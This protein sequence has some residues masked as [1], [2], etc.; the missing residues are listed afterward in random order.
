MDFLRKFWLNRFDISLK[1]E[2]EWW[3]TFH[4]LVNHG[5]LDRN[6]RED[7]DPLRSSQKSTGDTDNCEQERIDGLYQENRGDV[8]NVID[9]A[10]TFKRISGTSLKSE[11]KRTRLA[12]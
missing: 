6:E 5:N 1:S 4:E 3:E 11:F 7:Q 2:N 12:I 10:T 9:H 8:G